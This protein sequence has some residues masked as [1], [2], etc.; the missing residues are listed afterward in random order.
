MALV[1]ASQM[2]LISG[3]RLLSRLGQGGF[4]E[5][6]RRFPEERTEIAGHDLRFVLAALKFVQQ[7]VKHRIEGAGIKPMS[8]ALEVFTLAQQQAAEGEAIQLLLARKLA[9]GQAIKLG[10]SL[11]AA[12]LL[13]G[14]ERQTGMAEFAAR[15]LNA[16]H[17]CV[18]GIIG[19]HGFEISIQ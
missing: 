14:F 10:E 11:L 19:E 18:G 1:A 4:G 15:A 3:Y 17:R 7:D 12:L 8:P 9:R 6:T 5:V 2:E 13:F 16:G